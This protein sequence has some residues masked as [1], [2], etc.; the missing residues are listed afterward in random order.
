MNNGFATYKSWFLKS[1]PGVTSAFLNF[2]YYPC[3]SKESSN[4]DA[5]LYKQMDIKNHFSTN[6]QFGY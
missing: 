6:I 1:Y 3:L 5:F 4:K 2:L